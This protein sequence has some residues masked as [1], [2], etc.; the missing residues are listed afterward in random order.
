VLATDEVASDAE[1]LHFYATFGWHPLGVEAAIATVRYWQ[2]HGDQ[3]LANVAERSNEIRRRL[4]SALPDDA[5]LK[6]IGLAVAIHT[7]R[8][9]DI[10]ERCRKKGLIVAPEEDAVMLL[11]ALNIDEDTL[12]E[13]LDILTAALDQR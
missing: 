4:S 13:G 9:E 1:D 5:E 3:L 8:A 2:L 11:P 10:G 12:A 6:M 7:D